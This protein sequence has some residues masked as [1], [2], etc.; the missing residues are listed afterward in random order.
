MLSD[1]SVEKFQE[2]YRARFGRE[3]SQ[4]EAREK[5]TALMRFLQIVLKPM[6]EEEFREL[7]RRQQTNH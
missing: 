1:R 5:G 4:E 2:L 3:I 6:T 7:E